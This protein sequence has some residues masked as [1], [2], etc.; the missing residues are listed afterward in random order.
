[1]QVVIDQATP[2]Q[3][4]SF[5]ETAKFYNYHIVRTPNVRSGKPR[6]A[7]RRITVSDIYFWVIKDKRPISDIAQDFDLAPAQIYAAL[8]YYY[9]NQQEIDDQ[10]AQAEKEFEEGYNAQPQ[11]TKDLFKSL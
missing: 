11:S 7:G 10:I 1:M 9:D 5:F 3:T 2:A 4:A 6:I 8:A